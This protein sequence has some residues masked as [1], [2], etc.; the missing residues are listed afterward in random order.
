MGISITDILG[1]RAWFLHV[2]CLGCT[3]VSFYLVSPSV[4]HWVLKR[5][6]EGEHFWTSCI[7]IFLLY[8]QPYTSTGIFFQI[9]FLSRLPVFWPA[10]TIMVQPTVASWGICHNLTLWVFKNWYNIFWQ[11]PACS[12]NLNSILIGIFFPGVV[13]WL[14][15]VVVIFPSPH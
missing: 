4:E 6:I 3:V 2:W 13:L 14:L 15:G 11:I 5:C 1:T 7:F 12:W 10:N 8:Q 9:F